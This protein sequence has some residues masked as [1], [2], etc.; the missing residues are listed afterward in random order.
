MIATGLFAGIGGIEYGLHASGIDTYLLSEILPEALCVLKNRFPDAKFNEDVTKLKKIGQVDILAGGFPCQDLSIAGKKIGINGERSGLVREIFRLV[1]ACASKKPKFVLIENVANII[2]LNKGQAL[3]LITDEFHKLGY[4][5]AYRLIDP[6]S[7]GIPQRRP[8]FIFLASN[9]THPKTMLFPENEDCDA[10]IDDKIQEELEGVGAYGFYWTEGKIGIGWAK[11]SIPPLKCGSTLG[12]PSAPAVWDIKR[13]FFGTP[14]IED[15]ERLQGFPENWSKPIESAGFKPNQR[16]K[17]IGNAVNTK[18]FEWVG[19]KIMQSPNYIIDDRRVRRSKC[20]PWPKSAFN[21]GE[22]VMEVKASFYPE[23]VHY[24]PI[25]D[26]LNHPLNPLTL[27][28]TIGFRKRVLESTLI[29]YPSQFIE[30]INLFLLKQYG[31]T[32]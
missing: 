5:W 7:L 3:K 31:Y 32:D 22:N 12:L 26:F 10:V 25:L 8:R 19:N 28:A 14:T 21:E 23:G 18:V 4:D 6:R 29:K 2:S 27:R 15:A 13:N 20:T 30:S 17:L 24:T 1:D 11:D 9:I 16:W